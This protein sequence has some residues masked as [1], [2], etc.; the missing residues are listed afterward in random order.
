MLKIPAS[1]ENTGQDKLMDI[2]PVKCI[3][4]K[5]ILA[6]ER[7]ETLLLHVPLRQQVDQFLSL[8]HT[9]Q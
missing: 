1:V 8:L 2:H 3:P 6:C 4:V 9:S 5:N 7:G